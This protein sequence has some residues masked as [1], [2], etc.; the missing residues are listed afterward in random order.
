M[1]GTTRWSG[2]EQD[3][4]VSTSRPSPRMARPCR[5]ARGSSARTVR[6]VPYANCSDLPSKVTPGPIACH[7]S[8]CEVR[9]RQVDI[10]RQDVR[11]PSGELG[12]LD[13]DLGTNTACGG[14]T[15]GEENARPCPA[16]AWPT[17]RRTLQG[18][19]P[20][21]SL[22]CEIVAI[23]S[24]QVHERCATSSRVA[25]SCSPVTP[26]TSTTRPAGTGCSEGIYDANALGLSL[27]AIHEGTRDESVLDLRQGA[28]VTSSSR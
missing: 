10:A 27:I 20:D 6:T 15:F 22:T 4:T 9:L 23:N 8:Q 13:Q 5:A 18:I 24:Y 21:P 1:C 26:D 14:T 25:V 7:R 19:L 3:D 28:S 17:V 16:K 12:V 2:V 11:P